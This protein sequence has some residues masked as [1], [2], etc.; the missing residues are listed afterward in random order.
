[1]PKI[2]PNAKCP[3]DSGKKYKKCCLQSERKIKT[4]TDKI[5]QEMV[6]YNESRSSKSEIHKELNKHIFS[7]H[8]VQSIDITEIATNVNL[9]KICEHYMGKNIILMAE[10]NE[11]TE[12]IFKNK[13]AKSKDQELHEDILLIH[14]N[15]FMVYNHGTEE[16]EAL[17]QIASWLDAI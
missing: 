9:E 17:E 15:N 13:N 16:H 6:Q 10:R 2:K 7:K 11:Q 1:M 8:Q 14:R 3:C 12:A 5:F 4:D